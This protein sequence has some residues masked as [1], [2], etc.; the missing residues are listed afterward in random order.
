MHGASAV[1]ADDLLLVGRDHVAGDTQIQQQE[2]ASVSIFSGPGAES[3]EI[4]EGANH[5]ALCA[6]CCSDCRE[7]DFGYTH[8]LLCEAFETVEVD[9]RA[10]RGIV[11]DHRTPAS[12]GRA[13]GGLEIGDRHEAA[14]VS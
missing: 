14:T 13:D 8:G 6:D 7:V 10:V 3:L 1:H 11:P 2:L 4:I 5:D 12:S 9:L